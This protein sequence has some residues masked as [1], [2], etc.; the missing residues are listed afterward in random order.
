M[1]CGSTEGAR[2]FGAGE[3]VGGNKEEEKTYK[4]NESDLSGEKTL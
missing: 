4:D 1:M 2:F 3:E